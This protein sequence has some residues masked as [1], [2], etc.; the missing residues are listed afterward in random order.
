MTK[1]QKISILKLFFGLNINYNV[2]M[3]D[4][5]SLNEILSTHKIKEQAS[6]LCFV[7]FHLF[8]SLNVVTLIHFKLSV[9]AYIIINFQMFYL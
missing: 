5:V 2:H 8:A 3:V 1:N 7:F 4:R 6:G 9:I